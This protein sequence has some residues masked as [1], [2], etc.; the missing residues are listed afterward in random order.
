VS[1]GLLS[2]PTAFS[3]VTNAGAL[4]GKAGARRVARMMSELPVP[5]VRVVEK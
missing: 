3:S 4:Q 2:A 5:P 1:E